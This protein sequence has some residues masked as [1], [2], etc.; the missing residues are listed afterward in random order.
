VCRRSRTES[1][2]FGR[3]GADSSQAAAKQQP[4]SSTRPR[5]Q[6]T[7]K[8]K[9]PPTSAQ[10]Q[11][12]GRQL[13]M[14]EGNGS[15]KDAD[16]KDEKVRHVFPSVPPVPMDVALRRQRQQSR[17]SG[18]G[19]SNSSDVDAAPTTTTTTTEAASSSSSSTTTTT[20]S[21]TSDALLLGCPPLKWGIL[22]CGRVSH[23]WC[24]ALRHLPSQR[25][26]ACATASGGDDDRARQFAN[27]HGIPSYYRSYEQLCH[28]P[29]VQ[30]VYVGNIHSTR[31]QV[32]ELCLRHDKH[33]MVEK[34]FAMNAADAQY[35]IQ[36]SRSKP[37]L[38]VTEGM[39]TRYFPAVQH[40]RNLVRQGA[41]GD[42]C[43]VLSDF[44]INAA[45]HEDYP[46]SFFYQP[47]L[48]GGATLLVGPY[49]VAAALLA[50]GGRLPAEIKAVGQFDPRTG[51]DLHATLVLGF[52][53]PPNPPPNEDE[54]D[55]DGSR[56]SPSTA[57]SKPPKLSPVVPGCGTATLTY[58]IL[59]ESEEK[60][61]IIGT[62][63]RI[64]IMTPSHNPTSIKLE[65]KGRGRGAA[66]EAPAVFHYPLPNDTPFITG[67]GGFNYPHSAGFCYEAAAVARCIHD[68][69]TSRHNHQETDPAITNQGGAPQYPLGETLV[70]MRILD[71]VRRQIRPHPQPQPQPPQLPQE[72]D[73]K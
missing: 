34:P 57:P 37:H 10:Q 31:V 52:A 11:Q 72:D 60:T 21:S 26:V 38:F 39:W 25:V 22:G 69:E 67:A 12:Q 19:S 17:N 71:E 68:L 41:I 23:D 36:L 30:A 47:R 53:P 44:N 42:V 16:A 70:V 49:P 64:T 56:S 45:D 2:R 61:I 65:I 63:G 29:D 58:G 27:L 66:A 62:K 54:E 1:N 50:F 24:L 14:Q 55:E 9:T 15:D 59:C 40:A 18:T 3:T 20:A 35:L 8:T 51:V 48:G 5:S 28:D 33:V 46:G 4:S 43:T 13:A 7:T 6:T 73:D 32:V